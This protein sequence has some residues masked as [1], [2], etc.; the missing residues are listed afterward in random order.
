[1]VILQWS[2]IILHICINLKIKV[3]KDK[4]LKTLTQFNKSNFKW[5]IIETEALESFI[6][7][8]LVVFTLAEIS[9][10]TNKINLMSPIEST[11]YPNYVY[12][13]V[14]QLVN[15][16]IMVIV[17]TLVYFSQHSK[18]KTYFKRQWKESWHTKS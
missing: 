10:V 11:F 12:G 3:F 18:M 17:A 4:Q 2:S 14:H 7:N 16:I 15:P 6:L 1:M 5:F 8:V 13:N 9:F